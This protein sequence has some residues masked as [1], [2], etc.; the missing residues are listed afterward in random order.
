MSYRVI[1]SLLPGLSR[2]WTRKLQI[3]NVVLYSLGSEIIDRIV[4]EH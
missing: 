4:F 1:V 2:M 3:A